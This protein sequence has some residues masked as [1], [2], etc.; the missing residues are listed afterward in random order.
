[1]KA[2]DSLD[3]D[4]NL[5]GKA[6][7][8]EWAWLG[9]DGNPIGGN[10]DTTSISPNVTGVAY[11]K[12]QTSH[13][14]CKSAF[15][16]EKEGRDLGYV[17][18]PIAVIKEP[19]DNPPGQPPVY[20]EFPEISFINN[21]QG[22]IYLRWYAGDYFPNT[23]SIPMADQT[24]TPLP[25]T[26]N[27]SQSPLIKYDTVRQDYIQYD[28]SGT[29][30]GTG[31]DW[32]FTY[33]DTSATDYLMKLNGMI[34]L[35]LWAMNDSSLTDDT[36]SA[37][38]N[39]CGYCEHVADQKLIISHARMNFTVS[40]DAICQGDSVRFFDSTIVSLATTNPRTSGL[41]GWG[42]KFDSAWNSDPNYLDVKI[43]EFVP[44]DNY[45]P[46]PIFGKGKLITFTKPNKYRVVLQ[47]TCVTL[48]CFRYD[49]LIFSVLPQSVPRM[50]TSIDGI[51]YHEGKI[52]TIC[53]NSGGKYYLRDSSWSPHPYENTKIIGWEWLLGTSLRD[54]GK[55]PTLVVRN[56]GNGFQDLS[57]TVKNEYGCDSTHIYEY[58]LLAFTVMPSFIKEENRTFCNKTEI[59]FTNTTTVLPAGL[60]R[61]KT[62]LKLVYYWGDG[63]SSVVFAKSGERPITGHTYNIQS[64]SE[65]FY[66]KLKASVLDPVTQL[67]I[68]CEEEYV[69]SVVVSRPLA[70]FTDDGHE[71]PCP[72]DVSGVKGRTITFLDQSQGQIDLLIWNFGDGSDPIIGP[73]SNP[74][75]K[76]PIH[77]YDAAGI[78]TV[79][80]IVQDSNRCT[81][82]LQKQ[83]HV[84]IMGAR[85]DVT[86]TEDSS[87]CKPLQVVFQPSVE[88]DKSYQP[89]SIAVY[90][91]TGESYRRSGDYY[92]LT[93]PI[94]H[95]YQNA[96]AYLPVYFLYKTV[97]FSGG[98]ET[99]II[100]ISAK[101]T[102]YVI[103]L[104]T[105]FE[106]EPLYCPN[107]S[108]TFNNTSSWV[109]S[110]LGDTS[111]TATWDMGKGDSVQTSYH[112]QTSYDSAGIY[113]VNLRMQV[114]RCIKETSVDIEVMNIP[115]VTLLPDTAAAC[116]GL[117]VVFTADSLSDLDKSR[118]VSY[119]WAFE[120]G[121]TMTGNP[122]SREFEV[123]GEYPYT[124]T[125]TFSPP[126]CS[127]VYYDTVTI[128]AY[129]SPVAAFE[130]EP[131]VGEVDQDFTFTDKSTQ[132]EGKI[133]RWFWDYGDGNQS[134]D[135][136]NSVQKHAY[137][138]TSGSIL[139]TLYIKDEFGCQASAEVQI[140][141]TE[142][143]G[144]PNIF[145]PGSSNC[146]PPHNKCEFRPLEA[147]GYFKEFTME[148]Y[149]KNGMLVWR[150][151]CTDPNCPDYDGSGFWWDGTNKQGKQVAD[152][153]YYWVIY[154]LPLSEADPFIKNGSVT[155][156]NGGK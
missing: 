5:V 112:G 120:D 56:S 78:H 147:K 47:D 115:E 113:H 29:E 106:S 75:I 40:Q 66:V 82:S 3:V 144:F 85:G 73:P 84:K 23:N 105:K 141:V 117:E 16:P 155:V 148:V 89:D 18:P 77:R 87:N 44:I 108:I 45:T 93:R 38:F 153:V 12:L 152:G 130:A 91:G 109:P 53:I 67:P 99:C 111:V 52:D 35:Y 128:F 24:P 65:T 9:S 96:G 98:N 71:F 103:D 79:L 95:V 143:L 61:N 36:A 1:V 34:T 58:Q 11:V 14:G 83:D 76:S 39:Q 129:K 59:P 116:D 110:Y 125:L 127:K 31:A 62:A 68:G 97:N 48:K 51:N 8:N 19:T 72:D 54:T 57:L 122:A 30:V 90:V 139:V 151:R 137:S 156:I 118:I 46:D 126:G 80:L 42:F 133:N 74:T 150:N 114:L 69:D 25:P 81:D 101:D 142:K 104:D 15:T 121:T 10:S 145:S 28:S 64:L 119:E 55:T 86:Y 92:S 135:S 88:N 26:S 32:A 22:A 140:V 49:T 63:D 60:T 37:Y 107:T 27:Y 43:G 41:F 2:H 124:L 136:L 123:S 94:R 102:I 21:S 100:Q 149:N 7:A 131:T 138:T 33:N 50:L 17:C 20:C 70:A 4:S 154:A 132:G 13:N 6:W 134:P 146:P